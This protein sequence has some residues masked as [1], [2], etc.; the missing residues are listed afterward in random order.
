MGRRLHR[1]K[2][3]RRTIRTKFENRSNYRTC[4]VSLFPFLFRVIYCF[5]SPLKSVKVL[6]SVRVI[7]VDPKFLTHVI[8]WN[9]HKPKRKSG[10]IGKGSIKMLIFSFHVKLFNALVQFFDGYLKPVRLSITLSAYT[11]KALQNS[12]KNTDDSF[13]FLFNIFEVKTLQTFGS[14]KSNTRVSN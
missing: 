10:K 4:G 5:L 8:S 3:K 13:Q 6:L 9:S 14:L 12:V 11:A 7:S 1:K 2:E